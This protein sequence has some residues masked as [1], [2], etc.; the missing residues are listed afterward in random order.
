MET[1]IQRVREGIFQ[2]ETLSYVYQN[3]CY[4]ILG[5]RLFWSEL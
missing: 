5:I 2:T 3:R 1:T 4:F